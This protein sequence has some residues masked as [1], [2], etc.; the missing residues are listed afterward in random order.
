[1]RHKTYFYTGFRTQHEGL[2]IESERHGIVFANYLCSEYNMEGSWSNL[3]SS[4]MDRKIPVPL[5]I[6]LHIFTHIYTYLNIFTHF[7]TYLHI[8]KH[9]YT[10]L[11]QSPFNLDGTVQKFVS[12]ISNVLKITV[13][14]YE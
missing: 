9:I 6:F 3:P 10:Y 14:S 12:T 1:M 5:D 2:R 7:Y 13:L 8:F 4:S 11:R